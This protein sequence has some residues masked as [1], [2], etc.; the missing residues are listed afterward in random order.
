M[1]EEWLRTDKS[2]LR[3]GSVFVTSVESLELEATRNTSNQFNQLASDEI[4]EPIQPV[5]IK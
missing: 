4:V 1:E 3:S 5:H 2:G